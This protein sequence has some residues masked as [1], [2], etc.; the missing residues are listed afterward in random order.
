[1]PVVAVAISPP[2]P[3]DRPAGAF[4]LVRTVL[5][6]LRRAAGLVGAL[7][8][9]RERAFGAAP[10]RRPP[11]SGPAAADARRPAREAAARS[12][13]AAERR[14]NRDLHDTVLATLTMIGLGA[15]SGPS[16][17]LR[18]R[19][20]ADLRTLAGLADTRPA[21]APGP[22]ALDDRLRV[23][24]GRLPELP[25]AASLTRCV[26]PAEVAEALAGSAAAALSNVVRHAPGA[27]TTLRLAR[28]AGTVVVEVVDDG[29]GFDPATVPAHRYGLRS[30]STGGWPRW[31]DA[32]R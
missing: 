1:M 3:S 16:A 12:A 19:C 20:A 14:Q 22:V 18:A 15:V 26:L 4:T 13:R 5:A 11:V 10:A 7:P 17:A 27:S 30:P 29:P 8:W 9:H 25:V 21:P 6:L 2:S 23:V 24:L 28:E 32:Q 31:V